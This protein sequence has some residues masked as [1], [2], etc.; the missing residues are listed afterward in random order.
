[1]RDFK[2]IWDG[3]KAQAV[4]T[5]AP[6]KQY[7]TGLLKEKRTI[8]MKSYYCLKCSAKVEL[9]TVVQA[10]LVCQVSRKT[11]YNWIT[12]EKVHAFKTAG[13]QTRI[14]SNSLISAY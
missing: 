3:A 10:S 9:V 7:P 13:G 5:K 11:I 6:P 4:R 14:C 1:M 12:Q 2:R 8:V